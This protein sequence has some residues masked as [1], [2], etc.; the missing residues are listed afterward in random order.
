MAG[1]PGGAAW[2]WRELTDLTDLTDRP[3]RPDRQEAGMEKQTDF[4]LREKYAIPIQ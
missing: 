3:N 4:D 2:G 1:G